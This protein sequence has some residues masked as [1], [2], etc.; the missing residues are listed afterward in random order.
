MSTTFQLEVIPFTY[1]ASLVGYYMQSDYPGNTFK[2]FIKDSEKSVVFYLEK[3]GTSIEGLVRLH[4]KELSALVSK[5]KES[6]ESQNIYSSC[7]LKSFLKNKNLEDSKSFN[8]K[9]GN[10][11]DLITR[12]QMPELKVIK[13]EIA[14]T[15]SRIAFPTFH[16]NE[17]LI[18]SFEDDCIVT[19]YNYLAFSLYKILPNHHLRI[20]FLKEFIC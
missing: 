20:K 8:W 10:K 2:F 16:S 15:F 5:L 1:K 12:C 6:L 9:A 13:A 19:F 7:G 18:L 11:V 3:H 14:P 4:S 17:A